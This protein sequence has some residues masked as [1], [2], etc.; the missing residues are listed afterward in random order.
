M[1]KQILFLFLSRP[2]KCIRPGFPASVRL[3]L[4]SLTQPPSFPNHSWAWQTPGLANTFKGQ[5]EY[6]VPIVSNNVNFMV[7]ADLNGD[8]ALDMTLADFGAG[9]VSVF[10]NRPVAAFVPRALKFANQ[11]IDTTSP[12]Q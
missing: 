6:S 9:E 5:S 2:K 10:L 8:G 12:E 1:L 4:V 11:G 3:P 7:A